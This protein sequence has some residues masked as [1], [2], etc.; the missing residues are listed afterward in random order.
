MACLD[1]V[2]T[3]VRARYL[4]PNIGRFWTMDTYEGTE[5]DPSSLH[6]Y[7]YCMNNPVNGFD[8]TG[9][10]EFNM[11][12]FDVAEALE[13]YM[14]AFKAVSIGAAQRQAVRSLA[15]IALVAAIATLPAT[16]IGPESS[17]APEVEPIPLPPQVVPIPFDD[18]DNDDQYVVRGGVATVR[19]LTGGTGP[20]N[21][22]HFGGL[23]SGFSVQSA[24]RKSVYE[25]ARGG[26]FR[27]LQIS[28][29]RKSALIAAGAL[30]GY[31][32]RVVPTPSSRSENHC[33]VNAPYPLPEE[34]ATAL[35]AIFFPMPNPF[36]TP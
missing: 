27:N 8:P 33:T 1:L 2:G 15:K 14:Q 18:E 24:P 20:L 31:N 35:S 23:T 4:N 16:S 26:H 25:L 10:F 36:P 32:L 34:L 5:D 12:S 13:E 30:V 9:Q 3:L 17:V 11:P 28:V 7:A 22:A 21:P 6:K 19:Q 29:T